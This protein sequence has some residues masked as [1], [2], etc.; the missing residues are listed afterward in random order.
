M[1]NSCVFHAER[2]HAARVNTFDRV[3]HGFD[4]LRE[5]IVAAD[6][7]NILEAPNHEEFATSDKSKIS[8]RVPAVLER[9]RSEIPPT[10]Q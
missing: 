5:N 1:P 6:D 2:H 8:G 4:V 10:P 7:H 3:D 9:V